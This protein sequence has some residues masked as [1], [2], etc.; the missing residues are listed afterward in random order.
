MYDF[1]KLH[2]GDGIAK[3][4]LNRPEVYNAFNDGLTYDIQ[5]GI[6]EVAED[7]AVRVLVITGEGKAF[8]SGQ[9][10]KDAMQHKGRSFSESLHKRYNPIILALRQMPKPVICQLNGVAAGAGC[11][12]A[13]ACD[14]IIASQEAYLVEVFVNIGLVLDSG[15]A[16]F[17]PRLVGYNKAFE[18]STMGTRISAEE[19]EKLGIVNAVCPADE[20]EAKVLEYAAYYA[21]APTKA[22]GLMKKMLNRSGQATLEEIL[23]LEAEC[24]DIAGATTDFIEGV[25]AFLEK[26]RPNFKGS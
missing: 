20:L 23:N 26:R 11:S 1:I 24:Q 4:A 25:Q 17:L 7:P 18:L 13:L 19:A 12:I 6:T 21:Q 14:L 5:K 22:I 3:L 15:S 9:D 10:L 2:K 16:Y 8:S